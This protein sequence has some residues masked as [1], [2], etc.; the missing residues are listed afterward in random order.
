MDFI[1]LYVN[2]NNIMLILNSEFNI[3]TANNILEELSI[4]YL[5]VYFF[6]E[7]EQL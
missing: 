6:L 2:S 7:N 1:P 4:W 3:G 5:Y